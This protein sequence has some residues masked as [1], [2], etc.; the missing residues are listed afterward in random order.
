ML[1]M[2]RRSIFAPKYGMSFNASGVIE[3]QLHTQ[4]IQRLS[5]PLL[6][7]HHTGNGA[8]VEGISLSHHGERL[9]SSFTFAA[10]QSENMCLTCCIGRYE[11]RLCDGAAGAQGPVVDAQPYCSSSDMP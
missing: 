4:S 7:H 6:A 11:E 3:L 9:L 5:N 1:A 8:A 2:C 10:L